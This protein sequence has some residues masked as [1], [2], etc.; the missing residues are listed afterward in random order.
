[1]P[2]EPLPLDRK[3]LFSRER[4]QHNHDQVARWRDSSL[5]S[6]SSY[7]GS[8]NNNNNEFS[9]RWGFPS[10]DF[11]R[12]PGHGKQGGWHM[13][14]D[15]SAHGYATSRF[16][17]DRFLDDDG[18]RP[19]GLR[20]DGRYSRVYRENR[21]SFGQR[22]WRSHSWDTNHHQS[23]PRNAPGRPHCMNDL[24]SS[25]DSPV[26]VSYP[27][28]DPGDQFHSKD[29]A[30]KT[31]DTVG[32]GAGQRVDK[33]NS[34]GLLD[35][36]PLK[37]SRSGSLTS[38]GSGVSHS[39][40]SKS[41]GG[42][43]G[44]SDVPPKNVTP[45]QSPSGDAVAC[46]P[47]VIPCEDKTSTKKRRLGWGDGLA[48]YEKK[49][50]D[51]P[52]ENAGKAGSA[53]PGNVEPA[54]SFN[55]NLADK[56]PRI[57]GFSDCSSPATPSSVACSSSQGLEEKA[58]GRTPDTDVDA[59]NCSVSS[60]PMPENQHEG[61]HVS[62][63]KLELNSITDLSSLISELLQADE[64]CSM[65][66]GFVR[67]SAL[68]KLL[69]W[70]DDISKSLEMTETEIDSLEN[71][72]KSVKHDSGSNSHFLVSLH[73]LS[74]DC[75][76][77][78]REDL[79]VFQRPPP[80]DVI[81]SGDM[82]VG[83]TL[84]CD[85]VRGS[86]TEKK[87]EDV[88]SPGTATSKFVEPLSI[89]KPQCI[90]EETPLVESAR[91]V[92]QNLMVLLDAEKT[93]ETSCHGDD[94]KIVHDDYIATNIGK[95]SICDQKVEGICDTIL[96]SN[97]DSAAKASEIL[98]KLL[99]SGDHS[100]NTMIANNR[101]SLPAEFTIKEKFLKKQRLLRFKERVLSLKYRAFQHLWKEDLRL[102]SLK[103]H[104]TKQQKKLDLSSRTMQSGIQK[105]RSSVRSRFA[106]PGGSL[107]LVPTMEVISYTGKLLSDSQVRIYRNSLKMPAMILDEK[108]KSGSRFV[109]RNGLV[110]DPWALEK[111][112]ALINPWTD[113]EKENFMDKLATHGKDF[114][115][116][117]SFLDHKTTADCV[118]FYYKNH[119]SECF[120]KTK[121][122]LD[123]RKQEKPLSTS[124]YLVTSGKKWNREMN[125]ASLDI[126]GAASVIA[127]QAEEAIEP[128]RLLSGKSR[129]RKPR[130]SDGI[131]EASSS[132]CAAEDERETTAADVL[133]GICGSLSSEAMSS[134][135][136]S[137]VDP[138]EGNQDL[139]HQKVGSSGRR[140]LTPEVTQNVD[141]DP[142]SDES[143]GEMDPVDWTDDEKSLFVQAFS[144]YGKDFGMISRVVRT[145][146]RDQ[147]KVFFSKARKCLALDNLPSGTGME[148]IHGSSDGHGG[149]SDAEDACVLE[150]GSIACSDKSGSRM[151][152]DLPLANQDVS[153][154]ETIVSE[155][156]TSE[157]NCSVGELERGDAGH[158][159]DLLPSDYDTDVLG[160]ASDGGVG[161]VQ[162][163]KA[164]EADDIPRGEGE[165][166]T[167]DD[168]PP[169]F[170]ASVDVI[171]TEIGPIAST[172][173]MDP[174]AV[175]ENNSE[176]SV[177]KLENGLNMSSTS[178][179]SGGHEDRWCL[180]SA[181]RG[182]SHASQSSGSPQV[183][184]GFPLDL[185]LKPDTNG[186]IPHKMDLSLRKCGHEQPLEDAV[187]ELPLLVKNDDQAKDYEGMMCSS[188]REKPCRNGNVK[189]FGKI[190]S[191][192]SSTDKSSHSASDSNSQSTLSFA[193]G[194]EFEMKLAAKSEANGIS[195][196]GKHEHNSFLGLENVPIGSYGFWDGTKIQTGYSALPDSALL[197]TK[198]PAAFANYSIP[199]SKAEQ[200]PLGLNPNNECNLNGA[201]V[202]SPRELNSR[203]LEGVLPFRLDVKQKHGPFPEAQQDNFE[204]ISGLQPQQQGKGSIKLNLVQ[205]GGD[206]RV[207]GSCTGIS[208]P[209]AAL[210][211][212]YARTT[213]QYGNGGG[214]AGN[215]VIREETWRSPGDVGR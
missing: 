70:K 202:F 16:G 206:I 126:L 141:D 49:K 4:K 31:T 207:G 168:A 99:P 7:G 121:K 158:R 212:H 187:V 5:S 90:S 182:D 131:F 157:N 181:T 160:L 103:N 195:S 211:L 36:K 142:Y 156:K 162:D 215:G 2:P 38:R 25:S 118:E 48:K 1:M 155:M 13:Y 65:D 133:A 115:K 129:N 144:S 87:D 132:Y 86:E 130:G 154:P 3:E 147:C 58:Y 148:G 17:G 92:T 30:V 8:R 209:V 11:R 151:D 80:L 109:S 72:L 128:S 179:D 88:D 200:P 53:T 213:Q 95:L 165:L 180:Q 143:C 214:H 108:E 134:C 54:H 136:T 56:S 57:A 82:V 63:E 112:R 27:H 33:E 81:S 39:S 105:H 193:S 24:K 167:K 9:P 124:T 101:P 18:F 175:V 163:I 184:K 203:S 12:P 201:C 122:K 139:K 73:S 140:P 94:G 26:R 37:W 59:N 205:D 47:S 52:E 183:L 110:E 169:K 64:Q 204:G 74:M 42:D 145:K 35:W 150:T 102:L 153:K 75:K 113:E 91:S 116:I 69:L 68:N 40:C 123:F 98:K 171:E 149:G 41:I 104:R 14:P 170:E 197:L 55:S 172:S 29:Q 192:P 78:P 111:E 190:L 62:L 45:V 100:S 174:V 79:N 66:S 127:A 84:P 185:S 138:A 46:V 178:I 83:E 177:S 173:D 97:K 196:S 20:G 159:E 198:Y 23:V 28:S 50:V 117:A 106:S 176:M 164:D 43:D 191:K 89:R 146:S 166:L 119:K 199:S 186:I 120:E 96:V 32:P 93:L 77:Q 15:D 19:S 114:S 210:K 71:E 51:V 137:S 22:E 152:E 6:S 208:D 194:G 21:T 76:D 135:I 60:I 10:N 44:K 189:L 161:D 67:S 85:D 188:E 34:L 61:L 107:S 125:A